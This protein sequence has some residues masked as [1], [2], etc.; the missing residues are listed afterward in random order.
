M[1]KVYENIKDQSE[2]AYMGP[3]GLER[4]EVGPHTY[5]T[6]PDGSFLINFAGPFKTYPHYSMADV[7]D[8]T[9]PPQT[10][11][12]KIVILGATALGI[13]DLRPMPFQTTDYMGV[14]LHA[15][16]LDNLLNNDIPGRGFL[17]RGIYEE[18]I[19]IVFILLFGIGMGYLFARLKPLYSTFS[20]IAAL[21]AFYGITLFR[22][23]PLRDVAVFRD[24]RRRAGGELRRHH[25]L[26]HGV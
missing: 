1:L 13:G 21:L 3:N 2:V 23:Y 18:G 25:Q 7:I 9:V 20:V 24:S 26:P 8:G 15:N 14:E 5:F 22:L 17:Q 4:M 16:V 19:D 6:Q 10:F 11:K 12:G